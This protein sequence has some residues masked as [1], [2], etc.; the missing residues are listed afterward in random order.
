MIR[1]NKKLLIEASA[2]AVL[3]RPRGRETWRRRVLWNG[4]HAVKTDLQE[5]P[6]VKVLQCPGVHRTAPALGNRAEQIRKGEDLATW[7]MGSRNYPRIVTEMFFWNSPH[8]SRTGP[9]SGHISKWLGCNIILG[10]FLFFLIIKERASL[11]C[12]CQLRT[13]FSHWTSS[14]GM[15]PTGNGSL[16]HKGRSLASP[17]MFCWWK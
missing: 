17:F 9:P 1:H 2:T 4:F 15:R 14:T 16:C 10:A 11:V 3:F 5:T 6:P 13:C 12:V 7:L 8:C